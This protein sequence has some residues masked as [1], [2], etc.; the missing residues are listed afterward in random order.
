MTCAI[1]GG[2]AKR[3]PLLACPTAVHALAGTVSNVRVAQALAA[4]DVVN[5]FFSVMPRFE[6][7]RP[8]SF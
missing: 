2:H 6:T 3:P 1:T 5:E 7:D 8:I 4:L